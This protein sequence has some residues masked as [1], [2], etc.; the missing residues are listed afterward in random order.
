MLFTEILK[1]IRPHL[2][3]DATEAVFMR[4]IIQ[5]LC[6]V[7]EKDWG[8]KMTPLLNKTIKILLLE[9]FIHEES[10]KR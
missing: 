9:S 3:N 6:D 10:R 1:A 5:M 4:N 2:M 7:P 8:K